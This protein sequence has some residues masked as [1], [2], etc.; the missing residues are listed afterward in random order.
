MGVRRRAEPTCEPQLT[1][2][3]QV[4]LLAKEDDLVLEKGRVDP[5]RCR[6]VDVAGEVD[7]VDAGPDGG[8]ELHN[9]HTPTLTPAGVADNGSAQ[10]EW[11]KVT[12]VTALPASSVR[13]ISIPTGLLRR[14][15]PV[16]TLVFNKEWKDRR[17]FP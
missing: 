6:R 8:A 9:L 10:Q 17:C 7:T 5:R 12:V 13:H 16:V 1:L 4:V 3:V 11:H 15:F 14:T 2:V